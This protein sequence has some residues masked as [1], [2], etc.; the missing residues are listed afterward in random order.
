MQTLA[1]GYQTWYTSWKLRLVCLVALL[2]TLLLIGKALHTE[3][4]LSGPQI[5]EDIQRAG[6]W[7]PLLFV[8]MFSVGELLH[9]PGL[10]FVAAAVLVYGRLRGWL[11]S[12]VGALVAVSVSFFL[13]RCIG[14]SAIAE[15]Q[16]KHVAAIVHGITE[17]PLR[18]VMLLRIFFITLPAVTTIL[19]LTRIS[20]MDFL[21]GSALGLAPPILAFVFLLDW[22][23][24]HSVHQVF[25]FILPLGFG[26][27]SL[28]AAGVWIYCNGKEAEEKDSPKATSDCSGEAQAL[29]RSEDSHSPFHTF[30]G[31][32]DC[33]KSL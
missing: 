16:N 3:D 2:I 6:P 31:S 18:T 4:R 30:S 11:L 22:L 12:F 21:V 24:T 32:N 9:I 14:G 17:R 19:A 33:E 7:G 28:I 23:S 13:T 8:V 5:R 27:T 10:V 29:L 20:Y 1:D 26:A 25:Y 15:I